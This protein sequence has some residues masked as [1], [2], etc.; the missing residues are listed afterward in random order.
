MK[1]ILDWAE[2][3]GPLIA[4]LVYLIRKPKEKY[5]LPVIIYLWI[6]LCLDLLIDY[7]TAIKIHNLFLY[8]IHSICRLFLF[9]LFFTRINVFKI[10]GFTKAVVVAAS[11]VIVIVFYFL[12]S[13]FD[14]SSKVFAF[15]SIILLIYCMIYFF[16]LLRSDEVSFD[17]DPALIIITGLAVYEAVC[18]FI[19]LFFDLLTD[20]VPGFAANI[21]II[22]NIIYAIFCLFIARAFYGRNKSS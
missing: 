8:N 22:H 18:F 6:A 4:I 10:R 15:E 13:F 7:L 11:L 12:D 2:V 9:I 5:L 21:W 14:F 1:V 3:W 19:F 20:E 16:T 17:F